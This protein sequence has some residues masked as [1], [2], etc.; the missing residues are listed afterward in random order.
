[1]SIPCLA[2]RSEPQIPQR[3]TSM[4]TWPAAGVGSSPSI[5]SRAARMQ[6]TWRIASAY[7]HGS[8][9]RRRAN[10]IE[11]GHERNPWM[12]DG[13]N[14]NKALWEKGDFTRVAATMRGSGE[15]LVDRVGVSEGLEVLDLGSGDGT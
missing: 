6:V 5:T 11:R 8:P 1:S 12:E 9:S 14:A 7:C 2:C 13:M 15:A 3:S 10:R 4:R